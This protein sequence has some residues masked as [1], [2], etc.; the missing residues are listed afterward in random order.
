[1]YNYCNYYI[2]KGRD[3]AIDLMD[4]IDLIDNHQDTYSN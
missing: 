3:L 2:I 4:N 1:M